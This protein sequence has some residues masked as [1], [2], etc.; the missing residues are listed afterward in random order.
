MADL[1]EEGACEKV[2]LAV[3][4]GEEGAGEAVG[5][6]VLLPF[7][8]QDL[9]PFPPA[10][11]LLAVLADLTE[12]GACEKVG[13]AVTGG[14]EGAGEAVGEQVLLPLPLPGHPPI[15]DEDMPFFNLRS[16]KSPRVSWTEV[17]APN[18]EAGTISAETAAKEVSEITE[19]SLRRFIMVSFRSQKWLFECL[20]EALVVAIVLK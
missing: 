10:E 8:E 20:S 18:S 1:T 5:E 6:H 14:E 13:L 17:W 9:V 4:G 19:M 16:S 11:S 12:E 2:G 7:P 15:E 3:T